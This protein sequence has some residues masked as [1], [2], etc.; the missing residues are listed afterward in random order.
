MFQDTT[1]PGTFTVNLG[2]AYFALGRALQAQGKREDARSA[3]RSAT[4]H[5]QSALG[6]DHEETKA[7]RQLAQSEA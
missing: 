5:L 6:S 2:R 4:E 3:F 1:E 7:A